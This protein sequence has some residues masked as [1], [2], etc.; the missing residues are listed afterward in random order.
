LA[1]GCLSVSAECYSQYGQFKQQLKVVTGLQLRRSIRKKAAMDLVVAGNYDQF[2]NIC[3]LR[4][5][6]HRKFKYISSVQDIRGRQA[7]N[8]YMI[9]RYWEHYD[10]DMYD[11]QLY[12]YC[13][14]HNII[15][16]WNEAEFPPE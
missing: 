3:R 1:R 4:N 16:H 8:L 10:L 12:E 2:R 5:V 15:I 14:R 6:D 9:G 11:S 13:F 7:S